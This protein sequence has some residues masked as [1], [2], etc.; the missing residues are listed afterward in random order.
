MTSAKP[1]VTWGDRGMLL[2]IAIKSSQ[3]ASR[4]TTW[5]V[6]VVRRF[7]M[8]RRPLDCWPIRRP[9]GLTRDVVLDQTVVNVVLFIVCKSYKTSGFDLVSESV[10]CCTS[11]NVCMSFRCRCDSAFWLV[12]FWNQMYKYIEL[13]SHFVPVL[14]P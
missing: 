10:A 2:N 11:P 13:I 5:S 14:L 6:H 4:P 9:D 1:L 3:V 7:W 12:I 8:M